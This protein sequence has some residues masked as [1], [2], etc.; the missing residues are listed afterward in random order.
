M[1]KTAPYRLLD[2]FTK[3]K[4]CGNPLAVFA[5]ASEISA[6]E[7]QK[8]ASEINYSET[9]FVTECNDR[10]ANRWSVRIFTPR[11]EVPFAGHPLIGTAGVI[12]SSLNPGKRKIFLETISGTVEIFVSGEK[13]NL[14]WMSQHE[15][16]FGAV[17]EKKDISEILSLNQNDLA[18][19]PVQDV[20]TGLPC[21]VVPVKNILSLKKIKIKKDICLE[22]VKGRNAKAILAFSDESYNSRQNVSVR[23]FAPYYGIDEDAATGSANGCLAAYKLK[24]SDQNTINLISG[25][26]YEIARPSELYLNASRAADRIQVKVGGEIAETGEGFWYIGL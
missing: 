21:T 14:L 1:R 17:H 10:D 9:A 11:S 6:E 13:E 8:V 7:M 15:P 16:E 4:Y 5:D 26:G 22:Y 12:Y 24:L 2:V 3:E 23:V 19:L 25:Q 18:D 20:S